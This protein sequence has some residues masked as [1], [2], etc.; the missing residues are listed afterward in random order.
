MTK[1]GST[2]LNT[3]VIRSARHNPVI[4][5]AEDASTRVALNRVSPGAP[6]ST[7]RAARSPS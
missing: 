2:A 7:A 6:A 3:C 1:R 4:S 5:A